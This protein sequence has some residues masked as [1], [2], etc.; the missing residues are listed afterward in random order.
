MQGKF[1]AG[2]MRPSALANSTH[3]G[4]PCNVT[5]MNHDRLRKPDTGISDAGHCGAGRRT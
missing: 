4:V 3:S 5:E 2:R 1:H